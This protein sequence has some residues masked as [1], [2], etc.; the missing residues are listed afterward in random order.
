MDSQK[1]CLFFI[2]SILYTVLL[3]IGIWEITVAAS[4]QNIKTLTNFEI[5]AYAFTI[6]KS[7]LNIML[8]L[9]GCCLKCKPDDNSNSGSNIQLSII[10]SGVSIWGFIMYIKM[11][12]NNMYGPFQSVIIVEFIIMIVVLSLFGIFFLSFCCTCCLFLFTACNK[13]SNQKENQS[14]NLTSILIIK[15]NEEISNTT[16]ILNIT[17]NSLK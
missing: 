12:N 2:H 10:N 11:L 15:E 13:S 7:I 6:I 17:E 3:A 5:E 1:V 9:V 8:S 14:N 4:N 16:N